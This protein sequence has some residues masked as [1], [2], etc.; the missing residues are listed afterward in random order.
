MPAYCDSVK[1]R[2]AQ[3]VLPGCHLCTA[4]SRIN[5]VASLS[6]TRPK[7]PAG[8]AA[9]G[10]AARTGKLLIATE[11]V[12]DF[13]PRRLKTP[14]RIGHVRNGNTRSSVKILASVQSGASSRHSRPVFRH[15]WVLP[16]GH[17][18]CRRE[19]RLWIDACALINCITV[20]PAPAAALNGTNHPI[21]ARYPWRAGYRTTRRQW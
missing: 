6:C 14:R 13:P 8:Q 11:G 5:Q 15:G 19:R 2:A 1:W 17:G 18:Q 12:V 4:A 20:S 9:C 16:S 7:I 21:T 3:C 10:I